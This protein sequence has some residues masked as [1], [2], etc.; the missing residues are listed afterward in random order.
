MLGFFQ[1]LKKYSWMYT[2]EDDP[3]PWESILKFGIR[4]RYILR[5]LQH[6]LPLEHAPDPQPAV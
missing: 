6:T 4:P 2:W 3:F 1:D 5:K